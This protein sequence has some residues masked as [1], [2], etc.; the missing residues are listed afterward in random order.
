MP[1]EHP[2]VTEKTLVRATRLGLKALAADPK[3]KSAV[4]VAGVITEGPAAYA[5][6]VRV[7][8]HIKGEHVTEF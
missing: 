1:A 8:R 2:N 3:I 5:V 4:R 6:T 7:T